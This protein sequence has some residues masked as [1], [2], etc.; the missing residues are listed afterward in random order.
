MPPPPRQPIRADRAE[1]LVAAV[2]ACAVL[3]VLIIAAWLKPA[4]EGH[5]THEQLGLHPCTWAS[6]L[7]SPCPTCGMTTSFAHAAR[8]DFVASFLT[9]P[10]GFLLAL[11]SATGFWIALHI[12]VFGS[13]MGR[14]IAAFM[15]RRLL[16]ISLAALLAA[17]AYKIATW[18]GA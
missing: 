2:G 8:A 15:G 13:T 5:G 1:R 9:Q 7:G 10:F 6:V 17:W 12:A 18:Q 11:A 14:P 16:W 4:A 3:G